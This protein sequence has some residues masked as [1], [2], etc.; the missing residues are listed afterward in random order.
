ML[1]LQITQL[2]H[3]FINEY[4]AE[5]SVCIDAT[6]GNGYDT[7][8]LCSLV[9]D[10]GHVLSDRAEIIRDSHCDMHKYT[11]EASVDCIVFNFGYLPDGDHSVCTH[12]DTSVAAINTALSLLKKGGLLSLCVYSGGDTGF[13]EKTAI[14]NFVKGLSQKQYTVLRI[15][16]YNKSNNPPMPVMIIKL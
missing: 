4:V 12:A 15:D 6:A 16:Y 5:G 1:N 3:H 7:A 14:L 8:F 11:P 2:C 13:E 10:S 9:G